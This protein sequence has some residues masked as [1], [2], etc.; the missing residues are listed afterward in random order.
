MHAGMQAYGRAAFINCRWW[1]Y[2]RMCIR[3]CNNA[4]KDTHLIIAFQYCLLLQIGRIWSFYRWIQRKMA[5]RAT[6]SF[7]THTDKQTQSQDSLGFQLIAFFL[8]I[9]ELPKFPFFLPCYPDCKC[10]NMSHW[11][12]QEWCISL[13]KNTV[14]SG[15]IK[16]YHV[17][18]KAAVC[19]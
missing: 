3:K 1:L 14:K 16:Y 2:Y 5:W 15:K 4:L 10:G 17:T 18:P 11:A 12:R 6:S 7:F 13:H 8:Y 9:E 19:L